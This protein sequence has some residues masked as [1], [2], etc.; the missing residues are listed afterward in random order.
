MYVL[1]T[2]VRMY[3]RTCFY[4]YMYV[5]VCVGTYVCTYICSCV[6]R[7]NSMTCIC[8]QDTYVRT[9]MLYHS[10][11]YWPLLSSPSPPLPLS[12][13]FPPPFLP[14]SSPEWC[15]WRRH[16]VSNDSQAPGWVVHALPASQPGGRGAE[17][18]G[19]QP[20]GA[21]VSAAYLHACTRTHRYVV[22]H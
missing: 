6:A 5:H 10:S 15:E 3:V 12:S 7:G 22:Q 13:P 11:F 19:P 8:I 17:G 1:Q 16:C 18:E 2:Y 4:T 20:A 9:Y 21:A 14:L